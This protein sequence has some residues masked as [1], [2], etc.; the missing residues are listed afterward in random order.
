M[1]NYLIIGASSGIGKSIS[2]LLL[3][4]GNRVIGTYHRAEKSDAPSG[5]EFH[6][7]D[8]TAE[9]PELGFIPDRLDGMAYCPGSI[10]LK[11]FHRLQ[12]EMFL[13]DYH[14]NLVGAV[15]VIQ[16]SLKSLKSAGRSSIVMFSTVAVQTG[17]NFHA[18][19]ASSKGA[20]EGLVRSLAAELAPT[21]RVNAVAPSLTD[22]PMAASLLNTDAK[23][24]ANEQRHPLKRI[25]DPS[26]IAEMATFLLGERSGWITGQVIHVDGGMS[27]LKI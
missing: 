2:E 9:S 13:Q 23:R 8:V 11:P 7:L 15:K 4:E 16:A 18:Q 22:T 25:G 12:P 6:P 17:F 5:M 21:V 14:L 1:K 26:D 10:Q 19:V 24:E 3:K 20:V 27:R